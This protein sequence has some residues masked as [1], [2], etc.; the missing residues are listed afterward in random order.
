[1]LAAPGPMDSTKKNQTLCRVFQK[2]LQVLLLLAFERI[3]LRFAQ[4]DTFLCY[5]IDYY[6]TGP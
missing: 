3:I 2:H 5:Y 6:H 4:N 1:M